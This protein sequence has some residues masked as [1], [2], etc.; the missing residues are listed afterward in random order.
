MPPDFSRDVRCILGLPFDVVTEAQAEEALRQSID[1]RR[2]CFLSTPNL[3]F[4]A[5]CLSDAEFRASVLQSDL[6][7]ADG[8]PVVAI[9]RFI[10]AGLPGRAAGSSLFERL[11][12]SARRPPVAVYFFGGPDGAAQAAC[13]RLNSQSAGAV[14][15]GYDA[16]GFGSVADMSSAGHLERLNAARPDMVV[17]ALGA[18]K[19]QAWIQKNLTRIEAPVVSHLGAVV[20]FTA[21]AVSRAPRWLQAAGFEWLWRIKEEPSLWR[22]YAGDGTTLLRLLV[23]RVIP[24]AVHQRLSAPDSRAVENARASRS[25]GPDRT[26]LRLSGPWTRHNV[27]ALRTLFA[28]HTA[29]GGAVSLDMAAVSHLDASAIGLLALLYGWQLKIGA[30]WALVNPSRAVQLALRFACADYLLVSHGT[31]PWTQRT[32]TSA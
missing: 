15:T 17:V 29:S 3:N 6:N 30:A 32:N 23:T 11:M 26:I 31:R 22:R 19:G 24:F 1:S 13:K 10:G 5:G 20:N 4:A 27:G 21:G 7:L 8:W 9:G 16:P 2:R 18:K 12:N 28:S 14:C 25:E